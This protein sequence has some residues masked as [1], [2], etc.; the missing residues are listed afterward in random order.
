MA[1]LF[2]SE[3]RNM[4]SM[5]EIETLIKPMHKEANRLKNMYREKV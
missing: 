3:E 2:K 5:W 1:S 4:G